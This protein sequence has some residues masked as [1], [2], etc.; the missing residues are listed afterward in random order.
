[1]PG[2]DG[3]ALISTRAG[4]HREVYRLPVQRK[5]AA[6]SLDHPRSS[7]GTGPPLVTIILQ[8]GRSPPPSLENFQRIITITIIIIIPDAWNPA[9]IQ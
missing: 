9:F 3:R 1:M 7:D 2:D 8:Q 5:T 6:V 4:P